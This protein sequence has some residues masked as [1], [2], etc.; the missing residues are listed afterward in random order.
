M[1]DGDYRNAPKPSSGGGSGSGGS[2]GSRTSGGSSSNSGSGG[3]GRG[4]RDGR[5]TRGPE[6]LESL[7]ANTCKCAFSSLCPK[8]LWMLAGLVLIFTDTLW[9]S[10]APATVASPVFQ[11]QCTAEELRAQALFWASLD[12]IS[13]KFKREWTA[14]VD[15]ELMRFHSPFSWQGI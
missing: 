15:G 1:D 14:I 3:G 8:K 11:D 5:R 2:S 12:G 13:K 4:G 7:D 9:Q 10:R 6:S